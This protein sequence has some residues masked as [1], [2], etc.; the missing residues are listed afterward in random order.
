MTPTR[1]RWR[2]NWSSA[3]VLG[4]A[5]RAI[6]AAAA[7]SRARGCLESETVVG[8][9]DRRGGV[10]LGDHAGTGE[11]PKKMPIAACGSEFDTARQA[12]HQPARSLDVSAAVRREGARGTA[13]SYRRYLP[14]M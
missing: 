5:A 3:P 8:I 14:R 9:R 2:L 4:F 13:M 1:W 12:V 10:E 11:L 7:Q 6:R